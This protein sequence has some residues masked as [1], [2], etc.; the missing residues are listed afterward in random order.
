MG[1]CGKMMHGRF[2][3]GLP[4]GQTRQMKFTPL[5]AL[6]LTLRLQRA[7]FAP[8]TRRYHD[9]HVTRARHRRGTRPSVTRAQRDIQAPT[10]RGNVLIWR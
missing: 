7:R 4:G 1:C 10:G 9:N 2:E 6:L 5:S 8:M 3:K